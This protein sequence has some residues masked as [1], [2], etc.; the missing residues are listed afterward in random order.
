MLARFARFLRQPWATAENRA[1]LKVQMAVVV[2][3][4]VLFTVGYQIQRE[5]RLIMERDQTEVLIS[6]WDGL[7][8][9]VWPLAAPAILVLIRRF[10][11]IRGQLWWSASRLTISSVVLFVFVTNAR[12][13]LRIA[14]DFSVGDRALVLDWPH[15]IST[16]LALLPVDFLTYYG[17]FSA[18]FAIDYFFKHRRR[19]EEAL[20]LQA[21]TAQ[22]ESHVV[23]AELEVLRGQLHPH[24]LFNS[25]NAVAML[26]RQQ[27]TEAAVEMIAQLSQLL[28]RS[29]ERTHEPE[30]PLAEELDFVRRYLQIEQIRFGEKLVV[31]FDIAPGAGDA[32]VP[33]FLLQP[34]AENAIKHGIS[35][36]TAVGIVRVAASRRAERLD[37]VIEN[38]GPDSAPVPSATAGEMPSGGVGLANTRERL[39]KIYGDD[40]HLEMIHRAEGGMRVRLDLPWRDA[41]RVPRE[42]NPHADR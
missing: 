23:R 41:P 17:F 7:V 31:R 16:A 25:F 1:V 33:N 29:M 32:A 38:D 21:R 35:R 28:R 20:Q 26:V 13:L 36:R 18:T 10:P 12:F 30:L 39:E 34:L 14:P 27:R 22:L 9:I 19:Q 6:G 3:S 4:S 5:I 40:Y 42:K 24:F 37:L 2:G 15:Y 11:P 8:W